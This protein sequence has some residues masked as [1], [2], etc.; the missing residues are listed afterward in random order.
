VGPALNRQDN[1]RRIPDT[2]LDLWAKGMSASAI[3]RELGTVGGA[4]FGA[5]SIT[6]FIARARECG[7]ERA[8]YRRQK[9]TSDGNAVR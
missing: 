2:A 1:R 8:V 6:H 3:A 4:T 7:D 5:H 9:G